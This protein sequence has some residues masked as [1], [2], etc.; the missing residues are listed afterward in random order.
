MRRARQRY[1]EKAN[2]FTSAYAQLSEEMVAA[3]K[4]A[5]RKPQ[6]V[7][8]KSHEEEL[9]RQQRKEKERHLASGRAPI[10]GD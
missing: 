3:M 9:W 10:G 4:V 5:A 8:E 1:D 2:E 6:L 7:G